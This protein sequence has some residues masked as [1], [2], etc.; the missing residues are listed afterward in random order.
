M[1]R[2]RI[3]AEVPPEMIRWLDHAS[4]PSGTCSCG[5]SHGPRVAGCGGLASPAETI[6]ALLGWKT[7]EMLDH[8]DVEDNQDLEDGVAKLA[9]NFSGNFPGSAPTPKQAAS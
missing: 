1:N 2:D 6:T 8:Y 9:R 3:V 4:R 5:R 7:R